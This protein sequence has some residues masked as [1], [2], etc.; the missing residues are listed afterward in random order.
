M[1]H[2]CVHHS[3]FTLQPLPIKDQWDCA[4]QTD[5]DTTVLLIHLSINAPLD[6]STI[7]KLRVAYRTIIA[8]NILG[9]L[10]GRI[11]YYKPMS[12]V[13]KHI[14]RIFVPK[15][16]RHTIVSIMHAT[17]VVGYMVEY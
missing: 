13:T 16:L 15:S 2:Q 10:D 9:I 6:E 7:L 1:Y 12:T 3:P 5:P 14:S 8:R 11:V 4:Y 17:P